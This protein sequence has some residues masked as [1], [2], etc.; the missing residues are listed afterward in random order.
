MEAQ[1]NAR[2]GKLALGSVQFG[3]RYG[4][5]NLV[6]QPSADTLRS[7]LGV[8]AAA[9]ISV[10]DTAHAYGDAERVLGELLNGEDRFR[11]VTKTAPLRGA[12]DVEAVHAGFAESLGRLQRQQV[13]GLL[14]HHADDLLAAGGKAL[15]AW[16]EE[17]Q[18]QGAIGRIGVSVYTPEQLTRVRERFP[19]QIVQLPYNIYDQRFARSGCLDA[20]AEEGIEVHSRS[21]FLQGLLLM[22]PAMMPERFA[23]IRAHQERLHAC[24]ADRGLTPIAGA[25]TFALQD[26]RIGH[27]VV[28]CETMPQ[29]Q[30]IVDAAQRDISPLDCAAFALTDEA[31]IDPSRWSAA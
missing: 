23:S 5:A 29:L 13:Y 17:L 18:A 19:I 27:A 22:T 8:A 21:A 7:I 14:V 2:L 3:T 26:P 28:G 4:I 15:W 20:L 12:G 24:L 6:G 16:M 10:F 31:L 30:E 1:L 9:G 11:I 25:L